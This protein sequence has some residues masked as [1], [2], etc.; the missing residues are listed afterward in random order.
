M[1][2]FI[3][4]KS[5]LSK[6]H[7]RDHPSQKPYQHRQTCVVNATVAYHSKSMVNHAMS[8]LPQPVI[9]RSE[10]HRQ[11]NQHQT[12]YQNRPY[13]SYTTTAYHSINMQR[14]QLYQSN[15][16]TDYLSKKTHKHSQLYQSHATTTNHLRVPYHSQP[17]QNH[18]TSTNYS[19]TKLL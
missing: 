1:G 11:L 10:Y 13:R 7:Y 18:T 3:F 8:T 16:I 17:S 12:R 2:V 4:S 19:A 5:S 15:T 6:L 14:S 9:S